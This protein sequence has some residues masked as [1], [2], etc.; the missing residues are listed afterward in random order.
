[1]TRFVITI[2]LV[3]TLHRSITPHLLIALHLPITSLLVTGLL[4]IIATL[5]IVRAIF[6]EVFITF[7]DLF[8]ERP[9]RWPDLDC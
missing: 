9:C 8:V 7:L 4:L 6:L 3:F 2:L 5:R 1:M